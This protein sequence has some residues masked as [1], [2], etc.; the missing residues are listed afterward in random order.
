MLDDGDA[1][2]EA[3]VGLGEFE[4]DVSA[5][6]HDQMLGSLQFERFN[7]GEWAQPRLGPEWVECWHVCRA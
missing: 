6:K 5:A 3:A 1:P 2:A 4:P 7:M